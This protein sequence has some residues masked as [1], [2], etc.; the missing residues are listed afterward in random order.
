MRRID[1]NRHLL[2]IPILPI[3]ILHV[4]T[5]RHLRHR[6]AKRDGAD[7]QVL[8]PL[9]LDVRAGKCA[10]AQR[11]LRLIRGPAP[12][13]GEHERRLVRGGGAAR[14]PEPAVPA[15]VDPLRG[16]HEV[17][18]DALVHE[19]GVARHDDGPPGAAGGH[20]RDVKALLP[21][22]VDPL[23]RKRVAHL[24]RLLGVA[25]AL[26]HDHQRGARRGPGEG[27]DVVAVVPLLEDPIF[28]EELGGQLPHLRA[29]PRARVHD[30]RPQLLR[31]RHGADEQPVVI[32]L[33]HVL[34][35]ARVG[36]VVVVPLLHRAVRVVDGDPL[37]RG[38]AQAD[39][40]LGAAVLALLVQGLSL[41][42]LPDA[43]LLG[44]LGGDWP[45]VAGSAQGL[46]QRGQARVL[47]LLVEFQ[48]HH[49]LHVLAE[50]RG[51]VPAERLRARRHLLLAHQKPLVV[52]LVTLPR[53]PPLQQEQESVRQRLEIVAARTRA[54]EVGVHRR[55]SNRP[56]EDVG[57]LIVVDVRA[58]DGVAPTSGE[59]EVHQ[60]E[61]LLGG[62]ARR[63]EEEVLGLD[64]AVHEP[65][66]VKVL[67]DGE[68]L[69]R[70][71][72]DHL[73]RHD[74]AVGV[75]RVPERGPEEVHDHHVVLP[76]SPLVVHLGNAEDAAEGR[77]GV[78]HGPLVRGTVVTSLA[79]PVLEFERHLICVRGAG[80]AA[81]RPGRR[82]PPPH[83]HLTET[84]LTQLAFH[85][86]NRG[87]PDLG[88]LWDR[89]RRRI[90]VAR[91]LVAAPLLADLVD[92]LWL[93][94]FRGV[95]RSFR[96]FTREK[97][98][99]SSNSHL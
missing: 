10:R 41:A 63:A 19:T 67:E 39:L 84:T 74:L 40:L 60:V 85:D 95:R 54:P 20:G 11:L 2:P 14:D 56:P 87:A 21:L 81:A 92:H 37:L 34:L 45:P 90:V 57:P 75:P 18:L 99:S 44:T 7:V 69:H 53:Q 82:Y 64:V 3:P 89:R 30:E 52:P 46:E 1:L 88:P 27:G 70:D 55:V 23:E 76:L 12:G 79:A 62:G 80:I 47:G 16:V 4:E 13:N 48:V 73:L 58:A 93:G 5:L 78:V 29:E 51:R 25:R 96:L 36:H 72:R 31:A 42:F 91:G 65:L 66:A 97:L 28:G 32:S 33:V 68:R 35:D 43:R 24:V 49:S 50:R 61:L 77:E 22:L 6:P 8:R 71:A 15:P 86:V 59:P 83:V 98:R 17:Q 9:L 38:H 26:G 94:V